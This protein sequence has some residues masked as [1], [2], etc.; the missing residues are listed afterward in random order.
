MIRIISLI[1]LI[2][3]LMEKDGR[4]NEEPHYSFDQ[5]RVKPDITTKKVAKFIERTF[6]FLKVTLALFLELMDWY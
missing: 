3:D 5:G 6:E 2:I 1:S 4:I